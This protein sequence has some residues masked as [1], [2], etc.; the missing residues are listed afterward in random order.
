M[1][2]SPRGHTESD[3][4]GRLTLALFHKHVYIAGKACERMGSPL[5]A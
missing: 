1:G 2:Y 5:C 3:T 4:T